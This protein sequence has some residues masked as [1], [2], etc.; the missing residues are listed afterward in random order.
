MAQGRPPRF[1]Y[2]AVRVP[3]HLAWGGLNSEPA[4]AAAASFWTE[5]AGAA[6][7]WTD[8]RT[9]QLSSD[10]AS[11]GMAAIAA[12]AVE[13]RHGRP[14]SRTMPGVAQARDYYAAALTLL[15]RLAASEAPP[16][17]MA[18]RPLA[19]RPPALAATPEK[20]EITAKLPA[21]S[22]GQGLVR[23]T[24]SLLGG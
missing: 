6:P 2:D 1:S 19:L 8:L 18:A 13:S 12:V 16:P 11:P 10:L 7:A 23:R 4:L 14:N 21:V 9:G 15:A 17:G 22:F 20:P 3:L 5:T 24:A